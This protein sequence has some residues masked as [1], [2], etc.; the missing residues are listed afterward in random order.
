MAAAKMDQIA[1]ETA[2]VF[3]FRSDLF[4]IRPRDLIVLAISVV[5]AAL[6]PSDLVAGEQ[7]RNPQRQQH[8]GKQIALLAIAQTDYGGGRGGGPAPALP[9]GNGPASPG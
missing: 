3:V 4:P 5:V 2:K 1:D 8:C 6:C 9:A 7:H